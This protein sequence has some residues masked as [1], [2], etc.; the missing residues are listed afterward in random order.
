MRTSREFWLARFTWSMPD[1]G[2][3]VNLDDVALAPNRISNVP[4]GFG[5]R[6]TAASPFARACRVVRHVEEVLLA[7]RP[8]REVARLH[9]LLA[10]HPGRLDHRHRVAQHRVALVTCGQPAGQQA[11]QQPS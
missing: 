10:L 7:A 9:L 3:V 4:K 8:E 2:G 1:L 5:G 11:R 6:R